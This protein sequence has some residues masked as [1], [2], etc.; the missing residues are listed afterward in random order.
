MNTP[1]VVALVR[2]LLHIAPRQ[3]IHP[4]E[5]VCLGA[6]VWAGILDGKIQNM[7]VIS[8]WQAAVLR[9]MKEAMT[10]RALD[11]QRLPR[12]MLLRALRMRQAKENQ[13]VGTELDEV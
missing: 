3:T 4:D 8:A 13:V 12:S 2:N 9:T 10:R 11:N 6:G 1:C 7:E 5:A